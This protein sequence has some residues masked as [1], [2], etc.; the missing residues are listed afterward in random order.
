[1]TDPSGISGHSRDLETHA[2]APVAPR[3]A[4]G[5]RSDGSIQHLRRRSTP[6]PPP[7][8]P[9]MSDSTPPPVPK[10]QGPSGALLI[11]R[12]LW[13][14]SFLV[15]LGAIAIAFLSRAPVM[16]ALLDT[17]DE[18][19]PEYST[20]VVTTAAS[21]VFWTILVA[22]GVIIGLESL[23]L[24][25][26][27]S[28]RLAARLGMLLLLVLHIGV[29]LIADAF[30]ASGDN[31]FYLRIFLAAQLMLAAAGLVVA[32]LDRGPRPVE[33]RRSADPPS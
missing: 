22:L 4:V 33:G 15:G 30:L 8:R 6:P 13:V 24:S 29:A 27:L 32:V 28:R 7:P 23:I 19:A 10:I 14:L 9:H 16:D 31:G 5:E 18:V 2:D 25:G 17:I 1:M 26:L 12:Y 3:R 11:I 20:Q 21:I